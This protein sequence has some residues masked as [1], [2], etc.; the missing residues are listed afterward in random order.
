MHLLRQHK[1]AH[2]ETAPPITRLLPD[3]PSLISRF[4]QEIDLKCADAST[5][6]WGLFYWRIHTLGETHG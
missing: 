2:A 4:I 6:L 5:L 1:S 3:L